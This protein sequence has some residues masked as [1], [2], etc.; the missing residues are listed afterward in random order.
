M[1]PRVGVVTFP[2]SL[3]DHDALRAVRLCGAEPVPLSDEDVE[4]VIAL[5]REQ[6]TNARLSGRSVPDAALPKVGSFA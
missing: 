5:L 2:G 4:H 6:Q 3:D 1:A